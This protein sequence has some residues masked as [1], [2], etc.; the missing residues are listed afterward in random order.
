MK[1]KKNNV[2][3]IVGLISAL[4]VA[5]GIIALM[6]KII[7]DFA[8]KLNTADGADYIPDWTDEDSFDI[9]INENLSSPDDGE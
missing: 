2:A 7:R 9:D 3:L 5:A 4:V 8:A 1:D 6:A